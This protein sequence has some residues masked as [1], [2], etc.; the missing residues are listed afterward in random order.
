MI[1][2]HSTVPN[3]PPAPP[4]I[5]PTGR[6]YGVVSFGR[7]ALVVAA[8]WVA[9]IDRLPAASWSLDGE[10]Y[11]ADVRQD[12]ISRLRGSVTG[13]RLMAVGPEQDVLAVQSS[14]VAAGMIAAELTLF[15]TSTGARSLLLR[16]LQDHQFRAGRRR[17]GRSLHRLRARPAGV[18]TPVTP[19]GLVSGL[20]GGCREAGV[21][22]TQ[23]AGL[24]LEVVAAEDHVGVRT[25]TLA[26]P[27][28]SLLP[29]YVPGSH[30]VVECGGSS[31]AY[32]LLDDGVAS[33][34]YRI[35]VLLRAA[36][37]GGS[38][39]IHDSL[40]VGEQAIVSLPRSAFPPVAAGRHHVLIAA[41]I[42]VTPILS[43]A[44]AARRGGRSFTVLYRYRPGYAAH[45][46]ELRD[47]C[48]DRL[49]E[50]CDRPSFARSPSPA[51]HQPAARRSALPMRTRTVHCR[52]AGG[53]QDGWLARATIAQ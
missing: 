29:A 5:D 42:G 39:W 4:G 44:R 27:D 53:G 16:A 26:S 48:Q 1:P 11:S 21:T 28:G 37:A 33:N 6:V 25:L 18:L 17:R 2:A 51:P 19:V 23:R 45:L 43:H 35:S 49:E 8:R 32:S 50:F 47:L 22:V 10:S 7:A 9:E 40:C 34:R 36:G 46:A 20:P 13:L 12:L 24:L 3:W 31:N 14:A 41:G 15:A 52:R 30:L 38:R